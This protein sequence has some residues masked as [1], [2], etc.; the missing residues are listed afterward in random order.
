MQER[1]A[2]FWLAGCRSGLRQGQGLY[3]GQRGDEGRT[4]VRACTLHS[5]RLHGQAGR[6]IEWLAEHMDGQAGH[7]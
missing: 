5:G 1:C 7:G 2:P 3:R 4:R 6:L